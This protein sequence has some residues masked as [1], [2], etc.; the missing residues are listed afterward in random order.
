MYIYKYY[1]CF[2]DRQCSSGKNRCTNTVNA[3]RTG[4]ADQERTGVQIPLVLPGQSMQFREEQVYKY[5]QF[6][7]GRQSS[8]GKN[9]CTN[10][11]S[12]SGTG[13]AV[14]GRTGVQ[15]PSM[16]PGQAMQFREEQ[17]YK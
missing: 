14:Q 3:S 4:N 17:V 9:R 6:F 10:T 15:I 11:V 7:Q 1:Q 2:Q 12:S 13:N 8:S 16:I 5:R